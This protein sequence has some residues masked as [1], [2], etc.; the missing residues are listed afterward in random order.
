MLSYSSLSGALADER[1]RAIRDKARDAWCR[2][3]TGRLKLRGATVSDAADLYRVARLDSQPSPPAGRLVVAIDDDVL[4]AA[5]AVESG[6]VIADPFRS[7]AP[8][9]AL[10]RLRAATMRTPAPRPRGVFGRFA[11]VRG[12][13]A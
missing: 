12:A 7:T 2:H 3:Q 6:A 9:V 4:V 11:R 8:I 5:V 1:E 10:L 13:A